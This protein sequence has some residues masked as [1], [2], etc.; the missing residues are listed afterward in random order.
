MNKSDQRGIVSILTVTFMSILISIITISG[1][2]QMVGDLQQSTDSSNRVE[3]QYAAESGA[4]DAMAYL[5]AGINSGYFQADASRLP[6]QTCSDTDKIVTLSAPDTSISCRE[7][8]T[9]GKAQGTLGENDTVQFDLSG[10]TALDGGALEI[11]WDSNLGSAP[12]GGRTFA[13]QPNLGGNRP[14]DG[15]PALEVTIAYNNGSTN[16]QTKSIYL[17]PQ[18]CDGL[19]VPLAHGVQKDFN[20]IW[21]NN[22]TP[23]FPREPE[24][25][26]CHAATVASDYDCKVFLPGSALGTGLPAMVTGASA[27]YVVRIRALASSGNYA[28]ALYNCGIPTASCPITPLPLTAATIDVTSQVN[29]AYQRVVETPPVRS[30]PQG[31]SSYAL[32]GTD[33]ICKTLQIFNEGSGVYTPKFFQGCKHDDTTTP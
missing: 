28:A 11:D 18:C 3:A 2:V 22:N 32:L 31:S 19:A 15:P 30:N 20:G 26:L 33:S 8:I 7:V 4:A 29:G 27:Q 6:N 17:L 5:E 24:N 1:I 10:D 21:T 16:P 9:S 25:V 14:W 23:L 12:P 13:S